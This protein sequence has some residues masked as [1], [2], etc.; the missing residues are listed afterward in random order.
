MKKI[1]R[2]TLTVTRRQTVRQQ[3]L[4]GLPGLPGL[5]VSAV[6]PACGCAV[7]LQVEMPDAQTPAAFSPPEA[8]R[9]GQVASSKALTPD[10]LQTSSESQ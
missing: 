6:C 1:R 10:P 4:P 7:E 3:C 5:P 9:T 8:M 2:I